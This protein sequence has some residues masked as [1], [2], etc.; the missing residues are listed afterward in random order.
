MQFEIYDGKDI[1]VLNKFIRGDNF[2]R[3]IATVGKTK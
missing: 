1:E 3:P 2:L